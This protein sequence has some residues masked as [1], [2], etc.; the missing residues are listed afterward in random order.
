MKVPFADL[1]KQFN[2]IDTEVDSVIKDIMANARFINGPE[3]RQFESN[4]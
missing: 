4:F 3:C 2:E 1:K